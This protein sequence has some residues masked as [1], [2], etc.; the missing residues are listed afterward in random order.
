MGR[1]PLPPG[2]TV[3]TYHSPKPPN[4]VQL[5]SALASYISRAPPIL[6]LAWMTWRRTNGAAAGPDV[7]SPPVQPALM[8]SVAK[9]PGAVGR[10]GSGAWLG[11]SPSSDTYVNGWRSAGGG[12]GGDVDAA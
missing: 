10:A 8:E 11:S 2:R 3:V 1:S 7:C 9:A 6:E 12:G 4:W 5:P